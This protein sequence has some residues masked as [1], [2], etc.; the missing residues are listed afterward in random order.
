[1]SLLLNML[2]R[3]VITFLPRSKHLLISCL[4]SPSAVILE[5]QNRENTK[6]PDTLNLLVLMNLLRWLWKRQIWN[7]FHSQIGI[8]LNTKLLRWAFKNWIELKVS[9]LCPTLCDPMDY[10]VHGI[11]QARILEWVAF[12]FSRGSSQ[13]RDWTQISHIASRFFTS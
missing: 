13:P 6:P 9:Q 1:M 12:P 3:L 2:S 5:P 7:C 8:P 4:Q 10:I 11:F